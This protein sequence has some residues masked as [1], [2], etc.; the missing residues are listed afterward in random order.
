M[1]VIDGFQV[2]V[3]S[4]PAAG[5]PILGGM[6]ARNNG[7]NTPIEGGGDNNVDGGGNTITRNN[8]KRSFETKTPEPK[9]NRSEQEAS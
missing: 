4:L 3:V 2:L 7:N 8:L 6:T 5:K 1:A 9:F